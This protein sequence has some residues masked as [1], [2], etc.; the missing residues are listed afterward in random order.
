MAA[1]TVLRLLD[2]N[3][4]R[5]REGLR[6]LEDTAR[7]VRNDARFFRMFRNLRHNL[8]L[9]TRRVS[10][11]LVDARESVDDKGRTVKEG[12]RPNAAALV[13]ANFRRCEESLRVL[14]EYGKLFSAAAGREF[15]KIR[16]AVYRLE[17]DAQIKWKLRRAKQ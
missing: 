1:K 7:F 11:E 4:N 3:L 13:T 10:P 6:V 8:D 12:G 2:A 14:E 15:K 9:I 5:C 16:F 17:K